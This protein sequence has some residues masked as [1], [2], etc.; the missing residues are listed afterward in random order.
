[1][2]TLQSLFSKPRKIP[3]LNKWQYIMV[4]LFDLMVNFNGMAQPSGGPLFKGSQVKNFEVLQRFSS[5]TS[6]ADLPKYIK[7]Y[8][9]KATIG[10]YMSAAGD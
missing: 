9:S 4:L 7:K 8:R 1:M 5:G 2:K 10:A 3:L 6:P